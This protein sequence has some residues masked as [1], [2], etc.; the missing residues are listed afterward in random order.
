MICNF[1]LQIINLDL[2]LKMR[3]LTGK[4]HVLIY[5]ICDVVEF[6]L[7]SLFW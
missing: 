4:L 2:N 3:V 5:F 1:V 6:F 7:I